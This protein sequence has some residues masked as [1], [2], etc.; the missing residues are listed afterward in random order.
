MSYMLRAHN[1]L[2]D[3]VT[4]KRLPRAQTQRQWERQADKL[5]QS[6]RN[7]Q[8]DDF[9]GYIELIDENT[10]EIVHKMAVSW[11]AQ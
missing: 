11:P 5:M 8:D 9:E 4:E 10:G 1:N 7:L 3:A 6:M 2:T